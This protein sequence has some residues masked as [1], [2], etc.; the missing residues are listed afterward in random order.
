M[1]LSV[2]YIGGTGQISLPCVEASVAAG[3]KVTVLNRGKTVTSLPK[4][5]ETIVGDMTADA[6]FDIGARHFDVVAQFR[7]YTP[8]QMKRDIAIFTGKTGQYIFISSA[9]VYEKP[10]RHY[11]MTERTTLENKFWQYSRDKIACELLLRNQQELAYTIVRPSHTVRT[12]MPIQ[13][14]SP[15]VAIR[16]MIAGKPVI[17][18]GDGSSIWTV[19]RSVDVAT[20]LVRLFGNSL[21]L[22]EDYHITTD[23][24]F[25]WNQIHAAI[26]RGLGVEAIHAHV[27]TSV[28]VAC[29]KEW[30]GPL[31]GDKSWSALFD[32]SKIKGVVGDFDA[33]QDID[34]ILVDSIAHAKQRLQANPTEES[35]EGH[36][37]DR[38]VA[39]QAAVHL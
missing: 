7:L 24:G 27:P 8:A 12:H 34:E 32:N 2:L 1:A 36:L 23:R 9:S 39:A 37:M 31:M 17:V 35:A 5:V 38:I 15:D 13:V 3:H 19:T 33:S 4:G 20:P 30:E 22:S 28:L 16:R 25:T 10:V 14:G 26:A 6:Y 29:N 18:A 21:A 11:M